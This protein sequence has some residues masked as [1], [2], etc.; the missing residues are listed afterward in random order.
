MTNF[1]SLLSRLVA[2]SNIAIDESNPAKPVISA[3]GGGGGSSTPFPATPSE[4]FSVLNTFSAITANSTLAN[5]SVRAA[6]INI[7]AEVTATPNVFVSTAVADALLVGALYSVQSD[8]SPGTLIVPLGEFDLSTTGQITG[9]Q[10]TI[11]AGNYYLIYNAQNAGI[12]RTATFTGTQKSSLAQG[13]NAIQRFIA[14]LA[15]SSAMPTTWT[16][17]LTG[18]TTPFPSPFFFTI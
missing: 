17:A 6:R 16:T 18:Q 9:S 2:G 15:Y 4:Y 7:D 8:G 13:T 1:T 12:V 11:P 5:N 14:T 10:V 3:T